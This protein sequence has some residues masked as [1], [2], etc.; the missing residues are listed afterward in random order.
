V[1]L[2]REF[3]LLLATKFGNTELPQNAE[4]IAELRRKHAKEL[5]GDKKFMFGKYVVK[6][7]D[8]VYNSSFCNVLVTYSEMLGP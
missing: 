3:R 2:D 7:D 4:M 1:N 8:T 6:D 5:Y